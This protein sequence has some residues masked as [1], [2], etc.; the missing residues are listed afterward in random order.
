MEFFDVYRLREGRRAVVIKR[1]P[2]DDVLNVVFRATW[3]QRAVG[4]EQPPG[5]RIDQTKHG[6]S[7]SGSGPVFQSLPRQ[8][9][10]G[11]RRIEQ[12]VDFSN[13]NGRVQWQEVQSDSVLD[14]KL[15]L[16]LNHIG[17]WRKTGTSYDQLVSA[18]R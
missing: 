16:Y 5:L 7:R 11:P 15:R 8:V 13:I 2:V 18:W 9:L 4:F 6:S 14:W 3:M 12:C 10:S 1:D 17:V